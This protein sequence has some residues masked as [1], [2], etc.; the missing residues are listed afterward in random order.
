MRILGV[1]KGQTLHN[2]VLHDGALV[3][4]EDGI[5]KYA[6]MEERVSR[7]K[8]AGGFSK[9]LEL[10]ENQYKIKLQD[11]D[12]VGIS[13]C[14]EKQSAALLQTGFVHETNLESINH[15]LS[16]AWSAFA[17]SPFTDTLIVVI[18]GGGNILSEN[19]NSKWWEEPREQHS[20]YIASD[21][22][23]ELIDRDFE[24]AFEVGFGEITRAATYFVGWNSSQYA[25]NVMA[26]SSYGNYRNISRKRFIN[27]DRGKLMSCAK[28]NFDNPS[29]ILLDVGKDL[30]IYIGEPLTKSRYSI[31]LNNSYQD[32][33][34][35]IMW[36]L[37][38]AFLEK[39]R[40][41]QQK[42]G[43]KN[44]C[45]AG[46]FALNCVLN[47]IVAESDIFENVYIPSAPGD[48]GQALGNAAALWAKYNK[49]KLTPFTKSTDIELGTSHT[50][51]RETIISNLTKYQ[52]NN[53]LI[54]E[55]TNSIELIKE[56]LIEGNAICV[57][58]GRS[59]YGPR[60]LGN[61]SIIMLAN[62]PV[63]KLVASQLK[64]REW[65][66]PFAPVILKSDRGNYLH[67]PLIDTPFMSFAL[68]V[69]NDALKAFQSAVSYT[70]R[71]R[72]EAVESDS[73]LGAILMALK[74][75]G[76]DPVILNTSFNDRGEPIVET[77]EDAIKTF[78]NLSINV[79]MIENYILLKRVPPSPSFSKSNLLNISFP[80]FEVIIRG[81]KPLDGTAKTSN[82]VEII[83]WLQ[84]ETKQYI[85]IRTY[86]ALMEDYLL[87]LRDGSKTSTIR[88]RYGGIEWPA[89]S[90]MPVWKANE[91]QRDPKEFI[92]PDLYVKISK[93]EYLKYGQ[94]T[95]EDALRDGFKSLSEMRKHFKERIYFNISDE[96]W[97]TLYYITI[98]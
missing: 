61:R 44:L 62:N 94:L 93:I 91:Q 89:S 65:F 86:F 72:V 5:I 14:C 43:M 63:N 35:Y 40:Y 9:S 46:G 81:Y 11:I 66:R 18:D 4:V 16:H 38:V 19:N 10:L 54:I 26:L 74:D 51:K 95:Q 58:Q 12:L 23:I 27:I 79:L 34:A 53:T 8:R 13:T 84:H 92:N 49:K 15:H 42:T 98:D 75:L 2:K 55:H 39:L 87:W 30:N 96:D 17:T 36:N 57:F 59:E 88:R 76:E 73:F 50:I 7:L 77:I 6:F 64:N 25:S 69:R 33:C 3:L 21:N 82:S 1:N 32:L 24:Q 71:A 29:K 31:E 20:Y 60:A 52:L 37:E 78:S 48:N 45:I 90:R 28:Y 47:G 67:K 68:L 56:L 22:K 97:V 80:S 70:N 41:L 83:R 85:Y